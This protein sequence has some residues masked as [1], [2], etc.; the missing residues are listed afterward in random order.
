[1]RKILYCKKRRNLYSNKKKLHT[2]KE[3]TLEVLPLLLANLFCVVLYVEFTRFL[4][5]E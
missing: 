2:A 4:I 3:S 1:M 5:A